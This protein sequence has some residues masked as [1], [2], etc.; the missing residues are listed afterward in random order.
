MRTLRNRRR[1]GGGLSKVRNANT[2]LNLSKEDRDFL[3]KHPKMA[4][5]YTMLVASTRKQKRTTQTN[6]ARMNI[7]RNMEAFKE[8]D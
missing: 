5:Q 8:R 7:V 4:R 2:F 1:G 3:K 6:K